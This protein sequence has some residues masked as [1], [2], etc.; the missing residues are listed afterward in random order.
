M[1]DAK[2]WA[3]N[4]VKLQQLRARSQ[5]KPRAAEPEPP[6]MEPH[7]LLL[8]PSNARYE[9]EA[10][11]VIAERAEAQRLEEERRRGP[12]PMTKPPWVR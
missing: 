10:E 3:D 7:P 5:P 8:H 9:R 1:S 6:R 4:Y 2:Y 12:H 11:R